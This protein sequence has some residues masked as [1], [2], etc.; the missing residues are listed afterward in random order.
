MGIAL[1]HPNIVRTI[2]KE[3]DERVGDCIVLEY[4]DGTTLDH[5]LSTSPSRR[6]RKRV[7]RQILDAMEYFHAQGV[8]HRDLKP[9]NILIT[10]NGSNVKI[11]D[12]GLSDSDQYAALKQAAGTRRYAAPEQLIDGQK[13]DQSADIYAFGRLLEEFGLGRTYRRVAHKATR[14]NP[15]RR[16]RNDRAIIRSIKSY[17]GL[18]V[19]AV[20]AALVVVV[21]AAAALA[22]YNSID[23]E[24]IEKQQTTIDRKMV[25]FNEAF[26]EQ[27]AYL[28]DILAQ[29]TS[30]MQA[31]TLL[32][33]MQDGEQEA[34]DYLVIHDRL[35]EDVDPESGLTDTLEMLMVKCRNSKIENFQLQLAMLPPN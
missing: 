3:Q 9:Q 6:E 12:F 19:A 17:H 18:N 24:A 22:I 26:D 8:I 23:Y 11:I 2:T 13:I 4:V 25:Q 16:Y 21:A 15:K 35:L 27:Y 20:W 34:K 10:R 5:W 33:K 14:N 7:V 30:Q 31:W 28:N 32:V 1:D 29:S